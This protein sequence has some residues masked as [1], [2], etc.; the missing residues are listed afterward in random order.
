MQGGHTDS[1]DASS[2]SHDLVVLA[3]LSEYR[4]V[5]ALPD[6]GMDPRVKPTSISHA[7][8]AAESPPQ[9]FPRHPGLEHE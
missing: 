3:Q 5:D 9:V 1:V 8:A 2:I 7:T 6:R 4:L